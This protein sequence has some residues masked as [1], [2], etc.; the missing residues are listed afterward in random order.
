MDDDPQYQPE[1]GS[2]PSAAADTW[3]VDSREQA[4]AD[5]AV[6][7]LDFLTLSRGGY[8]GFAGPQI[9]QQGAGPGSVVFV[10]YRKG[11]LTIGIRL[12][13]GLAEDD[14]VAI[15]GIIHGGDDGDDYLREMERSKACTDRQMRRAVTKY[16]KQLRAT[17]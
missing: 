15:A 10:S 11:P 1:P 6:R 7:Q 17:M 5:E 8:R 16:A 4:F 9:E 13:R 14:Y 12:V 3:H 2:S